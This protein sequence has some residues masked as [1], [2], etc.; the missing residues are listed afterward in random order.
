M[1]ILDVGSVGAKVGEI[2][3]GRADAY[4]HT[5]GFYEWD[6][7]APAAVARAA[8]LHVSHVDGSKLVLNQENPKVNNLLVA[9]PELAKVLLD[10]DIA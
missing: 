7:A 9:R 2:I 3:A 6:V 8:G 1:E 5:T 4:V 10:I